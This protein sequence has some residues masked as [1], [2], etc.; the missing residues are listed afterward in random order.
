MIPS[1]MDRLSDP[2]LLLIIVHVCASAPPQT[3]GICW[4]TPV[5]RR[6][7]QLAAQVKDL[8]V[9]FQGQQD[10][11]VTS[12]VAWLTRHASQVSTAP[13]HQAHSLSMLHAKSNGH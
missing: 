5:C 4:V 3:P 12:F 11:Q 9:L 13:G 10:A 8:R 1:L 6:W 7:R 2:V